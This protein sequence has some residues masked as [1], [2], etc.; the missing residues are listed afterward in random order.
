[1]V[2]SIGCG[3]EGGVLGVVGKLCVGCGWE[4]DV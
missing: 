2:R 1:M 4:G 3:E